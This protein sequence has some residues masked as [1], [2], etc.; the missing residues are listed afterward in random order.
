MMFIVFIV[1]IILLV[2]L[3]GVGVEVC[4]VI[5]IIVFVGM[6]GVILFGLFLILVFYVVL[7]KFVSCNG[8]GKLVIYGEFIFYY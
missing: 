3:Y 1:G 2:F 5:G 6:L 8:G 4:L 7:C